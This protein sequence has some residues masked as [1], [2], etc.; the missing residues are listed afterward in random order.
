MAS[1]LAEARSR[2]SELEGLT[3]GDTQTVERVTLHLRQSG[4]I[5]STLSLV[6]IFNL[7]RETAEHVA[8]V[9]NFLQEERKESVRAAGEV[10][11]MTQQLAQSHAR[12]VLGPCC[13]RY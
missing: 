3:V 6:M 9:M 2:I 1:E 11:E 7:E 10:Y 13:G 8:V 5:T 4:R 12:Y